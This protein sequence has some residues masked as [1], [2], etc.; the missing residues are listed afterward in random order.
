LPARGT[1]S[2][3]N[4][5]PAG[6]AA[7]GARRQGQATDVAGARTTAWR[8]GGTLVRGQVNIFRLLD[9]RIAIR[10]ISAA[11]DVTLHLAHT[12]ALE[13]RTAAGRTGRSGWRGC[14]GSSSGDG[15]SCRGRSRGLIGGRFTVRIIVALGY[16]AIGLAPPIV[17]EAG[18]AG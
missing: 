11:G 5:D 13:A 4:V 18:T 10:I 9:R 8:A 17:L 1:L 15:R 7:T 16:V 3:L 14:Y 12:I 6:V 2:G